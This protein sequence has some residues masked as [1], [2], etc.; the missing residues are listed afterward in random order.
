MIRSFIL[1]AALSITAAVSTTLAGITTPQGIWQLNGSFS[2]TLPSYPALDASTLVSGTDYSF[3]TDGSGYQYLQTQP[4][5]SPSQ[6]LIVNHGVAPNGGPG[7]T[8]VNQWT[9]V[10]DVKLDALQPYA[11]LIHFNPLNN[12]DVTIYVLSANNIT[13]SLNGG[14]SATNAISVN[15]W[16]RMAITC[17]NDGNG[18]GTTMKL[19]LNG[20]PN[21]TPRTTSFD[22]LF[23]LQSSFLLFSD[24]TAGGTELKPAKLGSLGFWAEELSAADI[25]ALGGPVPQGIVL[26]TPTTI[27][28]ASPHAYGA[29]IGWIHAG[30]SYHGVVAGEYAFSGHAYSANCGWIN[31]GSGSP[32]NGI[33]YSN[34]NGADSG[35]NH[36]GAGNLSGLAWG[37]NIG[38]INFGTDATGAPRPTSDANRP[39]LDL[40][41]GQFTGYAYGANVG[42]INLSQLRTET[43]HSPDTDGDGIA[44]AWE[45]EKFGNLTA[46]N[47][48]SDTDGDGIS[49]LDE[50]IADTNPNDPASRLRIVSQQVSFFPNEG[51]NRWDATFTSSPR[52]LYRYQASANLG[53]TPWENAT[54][55][56]PGS[57][58]VTTS[59]GADVQPSPRNFFRVQAVKPLQ[60]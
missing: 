41:T 13:G 42:W 15:T 8:R 44:D 34:A 24:N 22:G 17:G 7:A 58:G 18:S 20:V 54:A 53:A 30:A 25:A 3:A 45:R 32:A 48:T 2:G 59:A 29:N 55:L 5:I 38:W 28:A 35:V 60:P 19:Y 57:Q 26:P 16:Y 47:A 50:H 51:Y 37:A 49:D 40:M 12:T 14:L 10:M 23:S 9:I 33:R 46:A 4:F 39:R 1:T 43:L 21:G 52:R 56:F 36:D 11:G 27:A 31:F 6:R